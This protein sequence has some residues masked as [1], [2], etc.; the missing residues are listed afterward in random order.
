MLRQ[1]TLR[2]AGG[3]QRCHSP[4]G[5]STLAGSRRRLP[6]GDPLV[7]P[8]VGGGHLIGL[9]QFAGSGMAGR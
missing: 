3:F 5:K 1:R 4:G 2:P 6:T 9:V 7:E 8:L